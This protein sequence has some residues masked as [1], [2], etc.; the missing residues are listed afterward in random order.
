MAYNSGVSTLQPIIG[1][2]VPDT[3]TVMFSTEIIDC[4]HYN[5]YGDISMYYAI[6]IQTVFVRNAIV[7]SN[8]IQVYLEGAWLSMLSCVLM[9][10]SDDRAAWFYH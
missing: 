2:D 9:P 5:K 8:R 10:V 3:F 6:D 7:G 1:S 4:R